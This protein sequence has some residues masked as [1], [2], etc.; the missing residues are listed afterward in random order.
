MSGKGLLGM[1]KKSA[2]F[3]CNDKKHK[4]TKRIKPPKPPAPPKATFV[5]EKHSEDNDWF[6][7]G[8]E[9][10]QQMLDLLKTNDTSA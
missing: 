2:Q 6:N 9:E 4:Q 3:H 5:S 10:L 8:E 7:T 1:K